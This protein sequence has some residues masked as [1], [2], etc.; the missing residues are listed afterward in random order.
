VPDPD[1]SPQKPCWLENDK[2]SMLGNVFFGHKRR[3][4]VAMG[5]EKANEMLR[6]DGGVWRNIN[7]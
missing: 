3:H 2:Q 1:Y 6:E 7:K 5:R 4:I